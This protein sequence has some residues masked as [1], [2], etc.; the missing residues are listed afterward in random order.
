M[1]IGVIKVKFQIAKQEVR[2]D[3]RVERGEVMIIGV[4][5]TPEGTER[6]QE[7]Q[8]GVLEG[9]KSVLYPLELVYRRV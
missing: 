3:F 8:D 4:G 6:K 1:V 5:E 9:Q 7:E 2:Q